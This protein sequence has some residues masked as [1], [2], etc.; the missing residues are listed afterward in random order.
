MVR[1]T[2][3]APGGWLDPDRPRCLHRKKM[4][5]SQEKR[6]KSGLPGWQQAVKHYSVLPKKKK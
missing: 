5:I 4:R 6:R 3:L 2:E 1:G